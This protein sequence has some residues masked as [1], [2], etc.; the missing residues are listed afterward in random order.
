MKA[1]WR[2]L[3]LS[4]DEVELINALS[5]AHY[6]SSFRQ[7]PSA[8]AL[9]CAAQGS[10]GLLPSIAAVLA[11]F[12][13]PHGPIEET[14]ETLSLQCRILPTSDKM[15][16]GWGNSFVKGE[17]DL[18]WAHCD[19]LIGGLNQDLHSYICYVTKTLNEAGKHVFPNPSCYTAAV[20]IT[21][22]MPKRLS[23]YLLVLGRLPAWGEM[24]LSQTKGT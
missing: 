13:W 3:P 5:E 19:L 14:Y 6:R 2:E 16:P 7:N 11:T 24:F 12:G 22:G 8:V 1:F 20:A 9:T 10:G 15:L 4:H 21:V 23:P 17:P 18:I